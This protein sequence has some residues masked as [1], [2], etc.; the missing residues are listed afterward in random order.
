MHDK[1]TDTTAAVDAFMAALEHPQHAGIEAIRRIILGVDP[2]IAEGIKWNAPSYRLHEYFATTHLRSKRGIG[3]ILHLGAK[4]RDLPPDWRV[5]DPAGLLTWLGKDRAQ[6][7][8]AGMDE[9]RDR[10]SAFEALLR[11]WIAALA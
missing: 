8:F 10:Q 6:I 7:E 11:Q 2:R 9:L 5:A 3:V 4:R 1:H